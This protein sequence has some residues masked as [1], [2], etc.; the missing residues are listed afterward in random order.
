VYV[1]IYIHICIYIYIYICTY[2]QS[3]H[4]TGSDG[5]GQ[6]G[7]LRANS[8]YA[9]STG[10]MHNQ[11]SMS[12]QSLWLERSQGIYRHMYMCIYMY[13][14]IHIYIYICVYICLYIHIYIHIYIGG[15]KG[16]EQISTE[17]TSDSSLVFRR[18][19]ASVLMKSAVAGNYLYASPEIVMQTGKE[20]S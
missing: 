1:Y 5:R 20:K 7:P 15:G 8:I 3:S 4:S 12:D 19:G 14:H 18:A 17:R 10:S 9:R 11:S 6:N 2:V 13:I 16:P